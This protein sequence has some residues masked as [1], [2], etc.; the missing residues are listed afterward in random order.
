MGEWTGTLQ[1]LALWGPGL[2]IIGLLY[3]LVRRPPEWIN[4]F[5][6]AQQDIAVSLSGMAAAVK[7]ASERDDYQQR[8]VLGVMRVLA[9]DMREVKEKLNG[10][11]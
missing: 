1:A 3:G 11:R 2:L 4:G 9:E 10:D 7:A 6:M 5:V 8:E